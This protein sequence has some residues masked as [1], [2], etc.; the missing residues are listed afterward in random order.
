MYVTVINFHL[1]DWTE[2]AYRALCDEVAPAFAEV[3]GLI[4]K[5]W[6]ADRESNTY[7]GVYLWRDRAALEE[8]KRSELFASVRAHPH[9]AGITVRDSAVLEEPTRVTRGFVP[10]GA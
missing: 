8:F 3:P 9:L 1:E 2:D 10:A 7:G 6:L 5:V 4:A